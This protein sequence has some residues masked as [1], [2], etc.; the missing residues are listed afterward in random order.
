[1]TKTELSLGQGR[2]S[3]EPALPASGEDMKRAET[4][5]K[6]PLWS[7]LRTF[8]T[9][10]RMI[11]LFA[12]VLTLLVKSPLLAF[13]SVAADAYR[14]INLYHY[15][16]LAADEDFYLS[17]GKEVLDGH[18]LG[19]P[20]IREGK[21]TYPDYYFTLNEYLLVGP[22][23]ILGLADN[24][25]IATLYAIYSFVGVFALIIGIY[26]FALHLRADKLFAVLVAIAVVSG[27]SLIENSFFAPVFNM[28]GRALHPALS[29]LAVFSYLILC[30][31]ALKVPS[32][33]RILIAGAMFGALSYIYSYAWTFVAVF[34]GFLFL[35]FTCKRDWPSA[36][37]IVF[38]SSLGALISLYNV[39]RTVSYMLS[40]A[41]Q[42]FSYFYGAASGH[43]FV[44][45]K[46]GLLVLLSFG[47]FAY[48]K[49]DTNWPIPFA[50]LLSGWFCINQQAL[51]GIRIQ[52]NHYLWYYTEP[53][54]VIALSYAL[55][56]Y[57]QTYRAKMVVC[58]FVIGLFLLNTTIAQ[59]N[60]FSLTLPQRLHEQEYR[61]ALDEL[62]KDEHQ[63]VV[64]AAADDDAEFLVTVYTPHDLFWQ[65]NLAQFNDNPIERHRD[66]LILYLYLNKNARGNP[67][68]YLEAILRDG[69][70][71]SVYKVLY[72]DIEGYA[73]GFGLHEYNRRVLENGDDF[74]RFRQDFLQAFLEDYEKVAKE[75]DGFEKLLD[76]YGVNWVLWDRTRQ[77]EWNL[78]ILRGLKEVAVQDSI[79]L[80]SR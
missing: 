56:S 28:Y 50:L 29:S 64:L 70:D 26:F 73:S 5:E 38:I 25:N 63:G 10:H 34:N 21:D 55:W 27:Y 66:A 59:F 7:R 80:Y 77:P 44:Y 19:N 23:Y 40:P 79:V 60:A 37:R 1:M 30:L 15:G 47:L 51:T 69:D 54:F 43:T 12:L 35:L 4:A 71:S 68:N 24:I 8:V 22:F 13:P 36:K 41:G 75:R 74:K 33:K 61:P 39:I 6:R 11:L 49:R 20:L 53:A 62:N 2:D 42:Q 32:F 65:R 46:L 16:N 9:E 31:R 72:Q 18:G 17:R 3:K 76:F 48:R 67:G 45:R 78:A 52:P 57:L 58:F 14:G